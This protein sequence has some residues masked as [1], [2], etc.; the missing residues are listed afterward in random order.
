[1]HADLFPIGG[2]AGE[3]GEVGD[4]VLV[5]G[6]EGDDLGV[7]GGYGGEERGLGHLLGGG[8]EAMH[9]K[10]PAEECHPGA[11]EGGDEHVAV[12]AVAVVGQAMQLE[13]HGT[14]GGAAVHFLALRHEG[15]VGLGGEMGAAAQK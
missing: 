13:Q 11:M 14:A 12:E 9:L 10:R 3:D 6:G 4:G 15:D 7:S 1:M 8:L 2:E 5:G